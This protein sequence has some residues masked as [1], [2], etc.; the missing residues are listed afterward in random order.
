MYLGFALDASRIDLWDI[1]WLDTDLG[2]LDTDIPSKDLACVQDVFKTSSAQQFFVFQDVLKTSS[3]LFKAP[4][5]MPSRRLPDVLEDEK[6]L[7]WIRLEDVFKK[8]LK[9]VFKTSWRPTNTCWAVCK[10]R[11]VCSY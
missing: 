6:L 11:F 10:M 8:C 5:E 2:L 4:C 1:E 7:C 3:N 9:D